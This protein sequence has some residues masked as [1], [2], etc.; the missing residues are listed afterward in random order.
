MIREGVYLKYKKTIDIFLLNVLDVNPF[1]DSVI[2]V[3]LISKI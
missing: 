3:I 2:S 1:I